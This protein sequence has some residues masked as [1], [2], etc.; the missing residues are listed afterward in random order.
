MKQLTNI[1]LVLV[2]FLIF[3]ST[4]IVAE[5]KTAT[6]DDGTT[7]IYDDEVPGGSIDLSIPDSEKDPAASSWPASIILTVPYILEKDGSSALASARMFLKTLGYDISDSRL[8]E[9]I[10]QSTDPAQLDDV[11]NTL[12]DDSAYHFRWSYHDVITLENLKYRIRESLNYGNPILVNTA[13]YNGE[14]YIRGHNIGYFVNH[15]GIIGDYFENGDIITYVDPSQGRFHGF[16]ADQS[17]SIKQISNA[18]GGKGYV[19]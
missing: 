9:L 4:S 2:L 6:T 10:T 7:V 3:S 5:Q 8:S 11:L 19:W 17:L 15:Y 1:L 16:M 14:V 12:V 13:E 18:A